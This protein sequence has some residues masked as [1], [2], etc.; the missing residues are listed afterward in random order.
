MCLFVLLHSVSF[1]QL[2]RCAH[3]RHVNIMK[4]YIEKNNI[5]VALIRFRKNR[6]FID[7]G[8]IEVGIYFRERRANCYPRRVANVLFR[9][10][11]VRRMFRDLAT[12]VHAI[13][14]H[15]LFGT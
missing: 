15:I 9:G 4:V 13:S 12:S 2:F 10:R 14:E 1:G 11:R 5:Q 7:V 6:D 8:N 3:K